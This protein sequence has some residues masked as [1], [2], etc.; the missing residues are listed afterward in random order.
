M[1]V[2]AKTATRTLAGDISMRISLLEAVSIPG[3]Y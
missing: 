1:E 3:F 2:A